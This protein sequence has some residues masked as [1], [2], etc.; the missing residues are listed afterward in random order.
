MTRNSTQ[1]AINRMSRS[2]NI[3]CGNGSCLIKN[4]L[5]FHLQKCIDMF[6]PPAGWDS[7]HPEGHHKKDIKSPSINTQRNAPTFIEQTSS[8]K[9]KMMTLTR[10]MTL[11]GCPIISSTPTAKTTAGSKHHLQCDD[12]GMATM[13]W[14][15]K[16]NANKPL[17]PQQLIDLLRDIHP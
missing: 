1:F 10:A 5:F 15:T 12:S 16:C 2:V 9:I 6:G 8:R 3:N 4:H 14:V 11:V 17:L 13:T 7:A